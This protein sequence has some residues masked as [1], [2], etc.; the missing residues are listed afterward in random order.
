MQAENAPKTLKE[1][2]I[3]GKD[4]QE[5]GYPASCIGKLLKKLLLHTACSPEENE[6]SRLLK[7][8]KGFYKEKA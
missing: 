5:Q 7:L 8:A 1:L 6:K 2:A 4:L 3:N